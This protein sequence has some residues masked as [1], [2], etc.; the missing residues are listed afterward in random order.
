MIKILKN[1]FSILSKDQLKFFYK[2]QILIA[3]SSLLEIASI[4]FLALYLSNI[5]NIGTFFSFFK[6]ISYISDFSESEIVL[7]L[8]SILIL[9]FLISTITNIL[10]IKY[11]HSFMNYVGSDFSQR[12][13]NFYLNQNY[14]YFVDNDINFI[15]KKIT[16]DVQRFTDQFLRGLVTA[17]SKILICFLIFTVL[18]IYNLKITLIVFFLL[19]FFYALTVKLFKKK[20][21]RSGKEITFQQ[22]LIYDYISNTFAG[23]REAIYYDR[24]KFLK[25]QV[26]K[27][28]N[29]MAHNLISIKT[30][31]AIPKYII[32]LVSFSILIIVI[33]ILTINSLADNIILNLAIFGSAG[34]KLLPAMQAIYY[35]LT[36]LYGHRDSFEAIYPEL[37]DDKFNNQNLRNNTLDKKKINKISSIKFKDVS[38]S[39]KK[40]LT[41]NKVD[42]VFENNQKIGIVGKSGSG[43][44]TIIDL[45]LGF[46]KPDK[47]S[48]LFNNEEMKLLSIKSIRN[49]IGFV[50]QG[51]F[52]FNDTISKNISIDKLYD[53]KLIEKL[54]R[55]C[56][57][58]DFLKDNNIDIE[59]DKIGN[60]GKS[61]SGGQKQRIGI[62][63]ALYNNP[64]V[65]ILDEAT[66]ALDSMN[67]NKILSNIFQYTEVKIII[68]ITHNTSL[69]KN[70]DNI[71]VLDEGSIVSE[72]DYDKLSAR[73]LLFKELSIDKEF[74]KKI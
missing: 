45:L 38:F 16:A 32:E 22:G 48:I 67:Q 62:A 64:K 69:L 43:K 6:D 71:F 20:I 46:I 51:I 12:L 11:Q 15:F 13:Y 65:L 7:I 21:D 29:A 35:S 63:R 40:S 36:D 23:I 14:L 47:G 68:L 3:I 4:G 37:K 28:L 19:L 58:D 9:L 61:L 5:L 66:S 30:I 8:S 34:Y 70:F 55:I 41:I 1:F 59:R 2:L 50:S 42:L 39:Y 49:L 54:S 72:G 27:N 24:K 52:L 44:S 57:I 18:L 17:L 25:E 73:S 56:L 10:S 33:S 26:K 74:N 31:G 53:R 60:Y